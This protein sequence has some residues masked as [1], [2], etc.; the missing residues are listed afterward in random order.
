MPRKKK[1]IG[2]MTKE[3][4]AKKFFPKRAKRELDKI[5]HEQDDKAVRRPAK[6]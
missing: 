2:E 1:P 6:T 5:A 3:E 4:L